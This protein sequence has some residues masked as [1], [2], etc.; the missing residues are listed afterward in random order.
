M[1]P[2]KWSGA[3]LL[4]TLPFLST[5]HI[6]KIPYAEDNEMSHC[7][8]DGVLYNSVSYVSRPGSIK[9]AE[10]LSEA[11]RLILPSK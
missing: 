10:P 2:A 3:D 6:T 7:A 9:D 4:K 5:V 1:F 11:E 8:I